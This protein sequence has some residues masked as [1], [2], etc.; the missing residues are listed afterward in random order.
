MYGNS[1]NTYPT[2]VA[3]GLQELLTTLVG[4]GVFTMEV[5]NVVARQM[6]NGGIQDFCRQLEQFPNITEQQLFS[7]LENYVR[8]LAQ[9]VIDGRVGQSWNRQPTS[10]G[11][12][13]NQ[14]NQGWGNQPGWG[15]QQQGWGQPGWGQQQSNWNNMQ[16]GSGA[17]M[18]SGSPFGNNRPQQA[19]PV[20]QQQQQ[21]QET[22]VV[23]PSIISKPKVAYTA[24]ESSNEKES[25]HGDDNV[26]RYSSTKYNSTTKHGQGITV[27]KATTNR[28]FPSPLAFVEFLGANLVVPPPR[29]LVIAAYQKPTIIKVPHTI[30]VGVLDELREAT[31]KLESHTP[32]SL[33]TMVADVLDNQPLKVVNVIKSMIFDRFQQFLNNKFIH[34]QDTLN[35]AIELDANSSIEDLLEFTKHSSDPAAMARFT[36]VKGYDEVITNA[37]GQSIASLFNTANVLSAKDADDIPLFSDAIGHISLDGKK[38]INEM[39]LTSKDQAKVC[40]EIGKIYTVVLHTDILFVTNMEPSE[41]SPFSLSETKKHRIKGADTC[42]LD[43]LVYGEYHMTHPVTVVLTPYDVSPVVFSLGRTV[44]YKVIV[45]K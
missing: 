11:W 43:N 36:D 31:Q 13:G 7:E 20:P 23:T 35:L 29:Y 19:P 14:M 15:Q 26:I 37:L 40:E 22:P 17:G 38:T 34:T 16:F 42:D 6:N 24:P 1:W 12:G 44:D 45:T 10:M 5:A 41:D 2:V 39:L 3:R 33:V 25:N 27:V 32:K 9:G 30:M 4:R 18:P 8:A 28:A 21:Q